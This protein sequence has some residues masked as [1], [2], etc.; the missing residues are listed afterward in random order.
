MQVNEL[1][2][3]FWV[4]LYR[5]VSPWRPVML[6]PGLITAFST[7]TLAGEFLARVRNPAWEVRLVVRPTFAAQAAQFRQQGATGITFDAEGTLIPFGEEM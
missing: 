6:T 1:P 5:D 2:S 3:S 4:L 7:H